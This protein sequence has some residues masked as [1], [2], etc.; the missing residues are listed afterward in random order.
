[1]E[2]FRDLKLGNAPASK[3][4]ATTYMAI[5]P[6]LVI[7]RA[8][9]ARHFIL[10]V[11]CVT[12]LGANLLGIGLGALFNEDKMTARYP[13]NISAILS[14]HFS[15]SF[16]SFDNITFS[17]PNG[18]Y[19]DHLYFAMANIT[20]G[21]PL[22]PWV[23]PEYFF[24][25][26]NLTEA[27]KGAVSD[28]YSLQTHGFGVNPNC[29]SMGTRVIGTKVPLVSQQLQN[30]T[31]C[32]DVIDLF[33]TMVRSSNVSGPGNDSAWTMQFANPM[34]AEPGTTCDGSYLFAW[35]K[36]LPAKVT[37][38]SSTSPE[39]AMNF[40]FQASIAK[41]NPVFETALFNVSVDSQGK[42]IS[43]N[44]TSKTESSISSLHDVNSTQSLLFKSFSFFN[45]DSLNI[46]WHNDTI[47]RDWP[48]Y[49]TYAK[50]RSKDFMD[51]R[52]PIPDAELMVPVVEDNFRLT[53]AILLALNQND[54]YERSQTNNVQMGQKLVVE[55]RIFL[56]KSALIITLTV[57]ALNI[58]VAG[59]FYGTPINVFLPRMP[60]SIGSI[61]AYVASSNAIKSSTYHSRAFMATKFSFGRYIGVDGRVHVGID[62]DPYVVPIHAHSMGKQSGANTLPI[63]AIRQRGLTK[64]DVTWL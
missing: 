36:S 25:P 58:L 6:Q 48:S 47:T 57:L 59:L 56:D 55:T 4:V 46:R 3:T 44:R 49:L 24:Q 31:Y 1:M 32:P 40:P 30:K 26:F 28:L 63:S 34:A 18:P 39:A 8:I 38:N 20:Q 9:K 43:Y 41:C 62:S 35:C 50:L 53:F 51:P 17:G 21:T 19:A 22:P 61:F 2:P 11:L 16:A 60:T 27:T 5:P 64:K 23:T 45:S 10:V 37:A 13:Q 15:E 33:T 14:E 29:T 7:W 52:K 54:L 12:A 42:V